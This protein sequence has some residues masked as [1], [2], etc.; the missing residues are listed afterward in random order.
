MHTSK[1]D[2]ERSDDLGR[3]DVC[4]WSLVSYLLLQ[5]AFGVMKLSVCP[6]MTVK[7]LLLP[8]FLMWVYAA[9]LML[10]R[11]VTLDLAFDFSNE[12]LEET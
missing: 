11:W 5:T 8:T 6:G 9:L 12:D 1:T 4:W 2:F 10:W 7:V 3:G